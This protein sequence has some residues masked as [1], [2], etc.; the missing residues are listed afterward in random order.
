M[1]GGTG[2]LGKR[3]MDI[4]LGSGLPMAVQADLAHLLVGHGL[5][6]AGVGVVTALAIAE[7]ERLM[8]GGLALGLGVT[9]QA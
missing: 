4:V 2:P 1:A 8:P 3:L 9:T 5:P 6:V 7:N